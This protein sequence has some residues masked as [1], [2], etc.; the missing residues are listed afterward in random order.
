MIQYN[1]EIRYFMIC[2]GQKILYPQSMQK[3]TKIYQLIEKKNVFNELKNT[4]KNQY[5]L[6]L[7]YFL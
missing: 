7:R 3:I 1:M 6:V 4:T 5:I 2:F